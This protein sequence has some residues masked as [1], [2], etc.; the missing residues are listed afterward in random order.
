MLMVSYELV[1]Y[2]NNC[3]NTIKIFTGSVFY[4]LE[5]RTLFNFILKIWQHFY[6]CKLH[7][8]LRSQP[9][10]SMSHHIVFLEGQVRT[11]IVI[12]VP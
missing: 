5:F 2:H 4:R 9:D 6:H 12:L 1:K 10:L 11:A 7:L 3:Y 8:E